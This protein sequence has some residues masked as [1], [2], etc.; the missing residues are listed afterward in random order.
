MAT[1]SDILSRADG[2][3]STERAAQWGDARDTHGEIA[4]LWSAYLGMNLFAKDVAALMI[5]LKLVRAKRSPESEDSYF[6]MAGYAA[7]MGEFNT[8]TEPGR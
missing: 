3:V 6:D 1:R 4:E 7:L 5:L 2:L 8:H